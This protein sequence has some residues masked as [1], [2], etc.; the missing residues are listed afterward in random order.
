MN[1]RWHYQLRP[2]WDRKIPTD[3]HFPTEVRSAETVRTEAAG[4]TT[5]SLFFKSMTQ[6]TRCKNARP[7]R[8]GVSIASDTKNGTICHTLP[9][10]NFTVTLPD[11]GNGSL[12][13]VLA[14]VVVLRSRT[15]VRTSNTNLCK[16]FIVDPVSSRQ[17]TVTP[18]TLASKVKSSFSGT[19]TSARVAVGEFPSTES[20]CRAWGPPFRD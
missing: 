5:S 8:Q 16:M 11:K 6:G 3:Y 7:S 19:L 20:G 4:V 14:C 13:A 2:R 17:L 18:E 15:P 1:M 9:I 12:A 10:S